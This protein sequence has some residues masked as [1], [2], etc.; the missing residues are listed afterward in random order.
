M[1]KVFLSL[2]VAT[3]ALFGFVACTAD[4]PDEPTPP[5]ASQP[6]ERPEPEP[7]PEP[8]VSVEQEQAVLA[9]EM[10]VASSGFSQKGLVHQLSSEYGEGFP[11]AVAE[12]AVASLDVDWNAEAV[13][14]AQLYMEM[15]GFSRD[16]L[17]EQ[18]SSPAGEQFTVEQAE[19]A[20]TEVGL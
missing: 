4:T 19:H 15:G 10:Y 1:K 12:K 14:A 5:A 16:G 7:A 2:V 13:E 17:V 11:K 18:L 3:V 9:A 6:A 20:A 8:K